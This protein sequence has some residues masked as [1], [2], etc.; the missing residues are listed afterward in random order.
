[1]A[2]KRER[3]QREYR[4]T[5]AREWAE[6][7][8]TTF[9]AT[10]YTLPEGMKLWKPTGKGIY[11]L[12]VIPYVVGKHNPRADPGYVH[13]ERTFYVHG[14]LGERGFTK[15]CCHKECFTQPCYFCDWLMKGA[16]GA[17]E[18]FVKKVR[19]QPRIL[20][21]VKDVTDKESRSLGV[22]L[23][24]QAFGTTRHPSFGN[25]LKNKLRTVESYA[26]FW[27]IRGGST[28]HLQVEPDSFG[29][30]QWFKIVNIEI[31]ERK[32]SYEPDILEDGVCLDDILI[33]MPYK[34]QESLFNRTP[35]EEEEA[36]EVVDRE[37]DGEEDRSNHRKPPQAKK[38]EP[39]EDEDEEDVEE[40]AE[41]EE[42]ADDWDEEL[43]EEETEAKETPRRNLRR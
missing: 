35:S 34:K 6:K 18:D 12:D 32:Y 1:M 4:E 21:K 8:E 23:L 43:E 25:L 42:D 41:E 10:V 31:V 20:M 26:N 27:K 28:L 38:A 19:I 2:N 15:V 30:R 5:N 39:D 37:E 14:G 40:E 29:G 3:E 17:D 11:K 33:K 24:D 13:F 22:Q 9:E 7:S 36:E 16:G